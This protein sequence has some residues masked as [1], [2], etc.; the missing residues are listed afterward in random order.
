M[1]YGIV[2]EAEFLRV[3]NKITKQIAASYKFGI[4]DTEDLAQ[5]T[6]VKCLEALPSW[7]K[8][9]DL[10]TYLLFISKNN[11]KN[12][13]RDEFYRPECPCKLCNNKDDGSTGHKNGRYCDKFLGWK[14]RNLRK[15]NIADPPPIPE[16]FRGLAVE[17]KNLN[18]IVAEEIQDKI[19]TE[20]PVA[21]RGVYLRMKNGDKVSNVDKGKVLRFLKKLL[22]DNE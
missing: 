14:Q 5:E 20:L 19:D 18:N 12:I 1:L 3:V 7:D 22:K 11:L 4:F 10:F 9:R 2:E 17:D 8:Q 16:D 15:A 13:K 21:L 6:Y